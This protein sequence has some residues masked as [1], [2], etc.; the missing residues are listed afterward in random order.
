MNFI[1]Y[2]CRI[3]FS[4]IKLVSPQYSMCEQNSDISPLGLIN[5]AIHFH[6]E[7]SI[8][9]PAPSHM[10][11]SP[12]LEQSLPSSSWALLKAL[13]FVAQTGSCISNTLTSP[14]PSLSAGVRTMW[15][16]HWSNADSPINYVFNQLTGA[17]S[18]PKPAGFNYTT[19]GWNYCCWFFTGESVLNHGFS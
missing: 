11:S 10:C 17:T 4:L 6:V 13:F 15:D 18:L 2:S 14:M 7:K 12:Q 5:M 16:D 1:F 9:T 8:I 3:N 19:P